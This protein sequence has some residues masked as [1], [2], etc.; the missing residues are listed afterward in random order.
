[1]AQ[2]RRF[3]GPAIGAKMADP[4]E[5]NFSEEKLKEGRNV[6]GLQVTLHIYGI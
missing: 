1:M 6:I 3:D 2:K 4:N 5:R